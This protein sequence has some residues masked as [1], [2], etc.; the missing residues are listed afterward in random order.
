MEK[1]DITDVS[2]S[3]QVGAVDFFGVMIPGVIIITMCVV[4]FFVPV[5]M[6]IMD[7]SVAEIKPIDVGTNGMLLGIFLLIIFSYMFGYIL[8]LSS[9][10]ELDR[11]SALKVIKREC[12][13]KSSK[14]SESAIKEWIDEDKWPF[15]PYDSMDKYP[16]LK[17]REYLKQRGH[18]EVAKKLITWNAE[19]DNRLRSKTAVNEMKMSV[20]LHC[21]E[22]SALLDSKEAHIRLMT[23]TWA[24]FRFS[25]WP[26]WIALISLIAAVAALNAQLSGHYYFVYIFINISLLLVIFFCNKKIENLFHYRRV[27]ELFHIVQAAY[28]AEEQ[29]RQ[30]ETSKQVTSKRK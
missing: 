6:L 7:L 28:F 5:A 27:S 30:K 26:I 1:N 24:A 2:R 16:Y 12:V 8:R 13:K 21:P 3:I 20:R 29:K 25:Q 9:P 23:G 11:T 22:L 14:K 19:A 15:N 18:T 10:D 17:F 4:G